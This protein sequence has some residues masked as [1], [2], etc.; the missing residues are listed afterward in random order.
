M[1]SKKGLNLFYQK[2]GVR[3]WDVIYLLWVEEGNLKILFPL[4][5]DAPQSVHTH[6]PEGVCVHARG[7]ERVCVKHT[8][9]H[10]WGH[11]HK[12]PR[13]CVCVHEGEH[14]TWRKLIFQIPTS[15][16]Q[17][18]WISPYTSRFADTSKMTKL[19]GVM[20]RERERERKRTNVSKDFK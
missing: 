20:E 1:W 16:T 11:E 5:F 12:H 2:E 17:R 15:S 6:T 13:V 4:K 14:Q 8:L 7:S 3:Y 9:S 18:R 10:S 19:I